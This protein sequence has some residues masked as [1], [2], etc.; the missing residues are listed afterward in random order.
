M[1]RVFFARQKQYLTAKIA[2]EQNMLSILQQVKNSMHAESTNKE[3]LYNLMQRAN[4]WA[5]GKMLGG[6][7]YNGSLF[8]LNGLNNNFYNYMMNGLGTYGGNGYCG[9]SGSIFNGFG[10]IGSGLFNGIGNIGSGL[11]GG[12][13]NM[14]GL[15]NMFNN[16]SYN[17]MAM[18]NPDWDMYDDKQLQAMKESDID[19]QRNHIESQLR[20]DE[21]E[22]KNVKQA[23]S[24]AIK[25]ESPKYAAGGG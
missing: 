22:L 17:A 25:E 20:T 15:G 16:N 2:R 18:N 12:L 21:E 23:E 5:M 1:S 10:N 13:A 8:N 24:N 6:N 4:D 11:F 3:R 14:F 9:G 7:N 19:A